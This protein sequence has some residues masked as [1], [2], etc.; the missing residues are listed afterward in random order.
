[1]FV[2]VAQTRWIARST[3]V[4]HNRTVWSALPLARARPSGL[5]TT[6]K[7]LT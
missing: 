6:A 2:V 1:V 7:K 4:S 5:N 3:F